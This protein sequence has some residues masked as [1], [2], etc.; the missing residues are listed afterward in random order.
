MERDRNSLVARILS[1]IVFLGIWVVTSF[2][3]TF[4]HYEG[5]LACETPLVSWAI[6]KCFLDFI[7]MIFVII[8]Y[9]IARKTKKPL[10]FKLKKDSISCC[11]FNNLNFGWYVYASTF[12]YTK[13]GRDC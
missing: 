7:H 5:A 10:I 3:I 6:G 8:T 12:L 9:L 1:Q 13:A 4:V 2:S 11:V